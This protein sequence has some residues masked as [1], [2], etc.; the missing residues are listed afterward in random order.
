MYFYSALCYKKVVTPLLA[1]TPERRKLHSIQLVEIPPTPDRQR[2][3]SLSVHRQ[4]LRATEREIHG[5]R[6]APLI[7]ITEL[8]Y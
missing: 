1:A 2:G 8:V 4:V 5:Q 7:K 3:V 6:M